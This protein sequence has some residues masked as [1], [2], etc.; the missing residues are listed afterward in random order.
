MISDDTTLTDVTITTTSQGTI[1][2]CTS[3]QPAPSTS[4]VE[5]RTVPDT[6]LRAIPSL[7]TAAVSQIPSMTTLVS[8]H[9]TPLCA[10]GHAPM[11]TS[12]M[13]PHSA[14][15]AQPV[16]TGSPPMV[17]GATAID[18]LV[19]SSYGIPKPALPRFSDGRE[20][21]FALLRMALDNLINVHPHL[22]EQ[23][24]F[25]VMLDRL[26]G[27]ALKLA[28]SFMYTRQPYTEALAALTDR[29]G[30]PRQLVQCEIAAIMATP[31]IKYGDT[32]AFEEFSLDVLSLVGMLQSLEGP[33]GIELRCGSH[34]DRLL[35]K[36]APSH[37]TSFMEHCLKEGILKSNC[38][39]TYTLPQFASWLRRKSQS[40]SFASRA[41][42]GHTL[43]NPRPQR[44]QEQRISRKDTPTAVLM[45]VP[46]PKYK[47][48]PYCPFCDNKEH[49]LG[50]CP[51]LKKL[52]TDQIVSWIQDKGRCWKCGRAHK[53]D[54]CTLKK[55]CHTCKQVHL[56]VL[57]DAAHKTTSHV[58]R[59]Q[60]SSLNV[61]VDRPIRPHGVML[62]VVPVLL[63]GPAGTIE[64]Y[65]ILDDGSERSMLIQTAAEKLQLKGQP[66]TVLLR[67]VRDDIVECQ[68][69]AMSLQVSPKGKPHIKYTINGA[70]SASNLCLSVYTYPVKALQQRY[71]HLRHL[72]LPVINQASPMLLLGADQTDL[73]IPQCPIRSGPRGAAVAIYTRLGWTLQGPTGNHDLQ[74]EQRVFK[75]STFPVTNDLL[76]HVQMLWQADVLPYANDKEVTRSKQDQYALKMLES[77]TTRV[78]LDGVQR[79]ATPLLRTKDGNRFQVTKDAV[80]PTLRRA[81]KRL[82]KHPQLAKKHNELITKLVDSGHVRVL[83]DDEAA[84]SDE[85]W[86]IPH[87]TVHHNGKYRLVF[88]CSFQYNNQVLNEHLLPGPQLGASLIGV[89]LRF[90]Q[91]A[92]AISG[93]IKA[94][95]HQ[96]RL[97][98]EDRPLFRFLWRNLKVE[99]EPQIHEW[100]VLPFG[101]TCSP[102]CATF[103][104]RKHA[105]DH[106]EQY[107]EVAESVD[108]SFYVDNC[109]DSLPSSRE[110][111][112][113]VHQ[114]R[115]L[116]ADAGFEIR[117]WASND[118][119]VVE[120]LPPDARSNGCELWLTYGDTD[121]LEATLGL[122][123]DCSTDNLQY[124]H[125]TVDYESLNMRN[126]YKILASQYDPIGYLTPFTTRA[127]VIVQDLWKTKCN[128]D[129]VLEPGAIRDQWQ[130]WEMELP[131]LTDIQLDRC[132]TPLAVD[133]KP[134]SYQL[135]I[136]CDA[137]ERAYGAVA[138][139][140]AEDKHH[141]IH[142]SFVMARSRVAPKRQLSM[143]RLELSAAL[144]GA[145]LC[146]LLKRELSLPVKYVVLW[147]DSTTVLTWLKSESCRYKVFVGTRVAEIQTLT[148]V[149]QWRYVNTKN[150]PADDLTRGKTLMELAQE[151]RWRD[152]PPFLLSPP[153]QW[154]V[155][156]ATPP[157]D[158]SEYKKSTFCGAVAVDPEDPPDLSKCDTWED[159]IM[160]TKEH[161]DG[162]ADTGDPPELG[163]EDR[164]NIELLLYR[165]AQQGSFPDDLA[166]LQA[167]RDLPRDSKLL[168]LAPEY[169]DF[170]GLIHVGGRLRQAEDIPKD[171]RHPIVMDPA[172][173]ITKLLI[174][175]YDEK[176]LHYG[177]ERVLAEMRRKFWVLRGRE[178]I[179]KHQRKCFGCQRWRANPDVPKMGDLPPARLRL[180]KPPFF[181]TGVD[182]FGP[183]TI[184]TGRRTEKRWG[185]IFKCMTTR[186]VHLDLLES[187]S[188]DAYLMAVRRFVSRRGKPFEILSDCG[189]NFKGGASELHEAFSAMEPRLKEELSKQ[190]VKFVF[191]P[192]KAP[193]FGGVWEREIKSVKAGLRVV[194]SQAVPEPVLRTVLI[195]IEGIL[196]S[197]PLGYVSS[198]IAD[199][200]PVTPNLLLM[201]RHDAALPQVVYPARDLLSRRHW[202][203]SQVLADHFWSRFIGLYLPSLQ[204]R[205]K[206]QRDGAEMKPDD[207]VMIVDPA[208]SRAQWPIGRVVDT[209]PGPD[210][211]VRTASVR[212]RKKNYTRPVARLIR[213]PEVTNEGV[214]DDQE[215]DKDPALMDSE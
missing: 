173:P 144:A 171:S 147:S 199:L 70:F 157:E 85:S 215:N 105:S 73:I 149:K 58:F 176:L 169:D 82:Q 3:A 78:S 71:N 51:Q 132:Y 20:K 5:N 204:I 98:P 31:A 37:R 52:N 91:H 200:D 8:G 148:D 206:W 50:G 111:K 134:S 183:M 93:D 158:V 138:Y 74:L 186:A 64:T 47:P 180:Y 213:L 166:A 60:T 65:A 114:M 150:N 203:H 207:V 162:A 152:G 139:L 135:H 88:N 177:P 198:D 2:V 15:Q 120:D 99:A 48:Q 28:K 136:F 76:Q 6:S 159:L 189:T 165:R 170:T 24:K 57:H 141:H 146:Q 124:R 101:S 107:P 125:R 192:P 79:Y 172:H 45:T 62:K 84:M 103:A 133:V 55:P 211:R 208:L 29:Y 179:R 32:E 102:C 97:L 126:M 86:F 69:S 113:L 10:D 41:V 110:A 80:L 43:S 68:G 26:G 33:D 23:Y 196:N 72:P 121:S 11:T 214:K 182:C 112:H 27:R 188:A 1:P 185:I 108:K 18:L 167:G 168:Q 59:V 164:A 181:S 140:R 191:N 16:P 151:S 156:P 81:E 131:A 130:A 153:D 22:T 137:S 190:Q 123:W 53:P 94:M 116:L 77:K 96:V 40:H 154:P 25:Q 21:E 129:D 67:T 210:G 202:K 163:A 95:F 39:Q 117:Q 30:Q 12:H 104:L 83:P 13:S 115:N 56:T 90:R 75:T 46:K 118:P 142:V 122:Q 66:E 61:Y 212:V 34:V 127:R 36:V 87:H 54:E 92:I 175:E 44:Y 119:T 128:W 205:Q 161:R 17:P 42:S 155:H 7:T 194:L 63:H 106:K 193:H 174:R 187:L 9:P 100:Q 14:H 160:A 89:L 35:S 178:A 109:L 184:K 209:F 49:Y 201:G 19:A 38:S 145:Q 197:K 4:P 143:P 195:E